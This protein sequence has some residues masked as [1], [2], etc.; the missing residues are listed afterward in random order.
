MSNT[1]IEV[2]SPCISVCSVDDI[3]GLCQGCYRTVD[4]IAAWWD[5]STD[6]QKKLL[7]VLE[8]RELQQVNFD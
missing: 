5:M 6:E 4:E 8:E 7:T 3:S 1:K 2:K